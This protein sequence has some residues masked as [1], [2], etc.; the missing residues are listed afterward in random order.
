MSSALLSQGLEIGHH[1]TTK[2][3]FEEE[4]ISF[5][6][7]TRAVHRS[8]PDLQRNLP[9]EIIVDPYG[10]YFC[11]V[12]CAQVPGNVVNFQQHL[13]GRRHMQNEN[14][15]VNPEQKA[16]VRV[17]YLHAA[18]AQRTQTGFG[19]SSPSP[20]IASRGRLKPG[21]N[22]VSSTPGSRT[23][24][25]RQECTRERSE[26]SR[27]GHQT[28]NRR[29]HGLTPGNIPDPPPTNTDEWREDLCNAEPTHQQV[30]TSSPMPRRSNIYGLVH[31][32][33]FWCAG[34]SGSSDS[35]TSATESA[36]SVQRQRDLI[37][38]NTYVWEEDR[39]GNAPLYPEVHL[40][41]YPCANDRSSFHPD[42]DFDSEAKS[43]FENDPNPQHSENSNLAP[44]CHS[45]IREQETH[46]SFATL[47]ADLIGWTSINNVVNRT[48]TQWVAPGVRRRI[49][50][51]SHS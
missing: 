15:F 4:H 11:F 28:S 41:A 31:D 6:H 26:V 50:C 21:G 8:N 43:Q 29:P 12:C 42:V 27:R 10:L 48:D 9:P 38:P 33:A 18:E 45:V 7:R 25:G 19:G 40:S 16:R 32:S 46:E 1:A 44:P 35:P 47:T 24:H 2:S 51:R 5:P 22:S 37:N 13:Q 30:D 36:W 20:V 49:C 14:R 3:E 39:S 34:R 17:Q 23:D